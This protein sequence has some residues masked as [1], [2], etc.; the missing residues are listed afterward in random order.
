MFFFLSG[1]SNCGD[2]N[3]LRIGKQSTINPRIAKCSLEYHV[4]KE[5]EHFNQGDRQ[6]IGKQLRQ[7]ERELQELDKT[8]TKLKMSRDTEKRKQ[9]HQC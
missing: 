4:S 2:F 9:V 5:M 8:C 3:L 6:T 1:R 7:K